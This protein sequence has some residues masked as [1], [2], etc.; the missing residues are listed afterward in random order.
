MKE[1]GFN[2]DPRNRYDGPEFDEYCISEGMYLP[3][4]RDRTPCV[5]CP[6]GNLC[7]AGFK[8]QVHLVTNGENSSLTDCKIFPEDSLSK[9][10]LLEGLTDDQRIFVLHHV[11]NETK[12]I[13]ND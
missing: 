12:E 13:A 9:D 1:H 5:T 3:A 10:G 6:L 11:F 4:G 8:E 2:L 7:E